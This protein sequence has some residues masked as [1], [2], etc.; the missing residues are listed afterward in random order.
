MEGTPFCSDISMKAFSADW[1]VP[2]TVQRATQI[3]KGALYALH[4]PAPPVSNEAITFP[5]N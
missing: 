4:Y 3:L 5:I 1:K 2:L